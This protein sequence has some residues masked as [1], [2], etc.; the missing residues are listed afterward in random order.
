MKQ[1]PILHTNSLQNLYIL[2]FSI[3]EFINDNN[4]AQNGPVILG[5]P[6]PLGL[7]QER[8]SEWDDLL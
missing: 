6:I 7:F 4:Y 8:V 2:S 3:L 5:C 1:P